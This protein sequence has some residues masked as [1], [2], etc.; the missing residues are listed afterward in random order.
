LLLAQRGDLDG[1][2][3][4]LAEQLGEIESLENPVLICMYQEALARV[5][6]LRNDTDA[7]EAHCIEVAHAVN[8]TRNPALI[9]ISERLRET[10]RGSRRQDLR[11]NIILD[12]VTTVVNVT[13]SPPTMLDSTPTADTTALGHSLLDRVLSSCH[14]PA[15]RSERALELLV[16]ASSGKVGYL[17]VV[18]DDAPTLSAP[19]FAE[20]PPA[21][22]AQIDALLHRAASDENR[23]GTIDLDGERWHLTALVLAIGAHER[24]VG[25]LA[26]RE[27]AI[28]YQPPTTML[29][30][31]IAKELYE[32]GDATALDTHS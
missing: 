4:L 21:L 10:L 26:I 22:V 13:T 31:Q 18:R 11:A 24:I 12:S 6:L 23:T 19:P 8:P 14:G 20:P 5:A 16:L 17:F 1:A 32:A 3:A 15:A 30:Q 27:G 29:I 25:A 2:E 28:R 9:A 7:F